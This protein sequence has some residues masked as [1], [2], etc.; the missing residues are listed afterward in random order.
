VKTKPSERDVAMAKDW[1]QL[2]SCFTAARLATLQA[3]LAQARKEGP[4]LTEDDR[5]LIRL[6]HTKGKT[7]VET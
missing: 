7:H 6:T 5:M 4:E 3:L 1:L 2:E